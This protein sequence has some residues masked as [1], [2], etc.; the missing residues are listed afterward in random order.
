M[1]A[2]L[3]KTRTRPAPG[4]IDLWEAFY[5]P[6]T[7]GR[8][9]CLGALSF[10]YYAL[11]PTTLRL[12]IGRPIDI[13]RGSC[14]LVAVGPLCDD[15]KHLSARYVLTRDAIHWRYSYEQKLALYRRLAASNT[16]EKGLPASQFM[17][18]R[19]ALNLKPTELGVA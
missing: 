12:E 19:T 11:S 5:S 3:E 1:L 6:D 17:D 13:K 15:S 14:P 2:T 4:E 16:N 9:R 10:L 7:G 8:V 18:A